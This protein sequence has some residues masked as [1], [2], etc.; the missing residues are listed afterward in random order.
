MQLE[1][2]EDRGTKFETG[3]E[4]IARAGWLV[5]GRDLCTLGYFEI[6]IT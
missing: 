5:S 3:T 1:K 2:Q 4:E 6:H